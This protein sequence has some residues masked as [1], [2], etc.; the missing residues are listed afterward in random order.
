M[1]LAALTYMLGAGIARYLGLPI[2]LLPLIVGLAVAILFQSA[3]SLLAAGFRARREAPAGADAQEDTDLL[4]N[5]ALRI[6][7]AAMVTAVLVTLALSRNEGISKD[8]WLYVAISL[9]MV[10]VYA[11]PPARLLDRGL[12]EGLLAVQVAYVT[13]ALGFSLQAGGYHRLLGACTAALTM[14]LVG[15]LIALGFSSYAED[16]RHERSTL[17]TTL[18]WH[19]AVGIHHAL[20]ISAYALLGISGLL[21]FSFRIFLPAFLTLPFAALQIFVLRQ[22]TRGAKPMWRLLNTTAISAFGLTAYFLTLSF[23]LR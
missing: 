7:V 11:V 15:M 23:W 9:L 22:I 20:V 18:G 6:S 10:V 12:G 16:L 13:P 14:L 1:M 21:G 3:L 17:L 19:R 5:A 8:A 4:R 2:R